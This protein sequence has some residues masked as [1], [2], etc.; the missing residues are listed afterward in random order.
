[1]DTLFMRGFFLS[2]PQNITIREKPVNAE[3]KRGAPGEKII[4]IHFDFYYAL[5]DEELEEG[6]YED[7]GF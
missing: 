2:Y 7:L 1:M 6:L 3:M 5:Y 4:A